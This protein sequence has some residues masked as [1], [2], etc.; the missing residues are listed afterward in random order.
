MKKV[1]ETVEKQKT[2]KEWKASMA[3][4]TESFCLKTEAVPEDV[5]MRMSEELIDWAKNCPDALRL[6]QF[7]NKYNITRHYVISWRKKYPWFNNVMDMAFSI[8]ADRREI[9]GLQ[10]KL[11]A[12]YVLFTQGMYD[13][14]MKDFLVFKSKLREEGEQGPTTVLIKKFVE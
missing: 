13:P 2:R 12:Q 4:C 10:N 3:L 8:I 9:L 6:G 1:V 14:D 11:N 7:W 5:L